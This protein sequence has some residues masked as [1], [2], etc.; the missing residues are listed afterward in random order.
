[1]SEFMALTEIPILIVYGDDIPAEPSN[2][3]TQDAWRVRLKMAREWRDAVNRHG[4][5][6]TLFRLP[7]IGITGNTHFPFSDLNNV[8][9]AN[10][11]SKFSEEKYLD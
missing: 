11:V 10:E 3:P 1:M 8:R 9:I 5:D 2:V 6:V 7:E 4:G